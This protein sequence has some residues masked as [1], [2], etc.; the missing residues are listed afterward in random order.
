MSRRRS[1][2]ASTCGG[3]APAAAAPL[4][5][6]AFLHPDL[7]L[8]GAERLVVDAA[9]GLCRL[10]HGVEVF[11]SHYEPARSFAETRS[12][13]FPVHVHGDW[14]PR[15]VLGRLHIL[16]ALLRMLWLALRV[17]LRAGAFDV[18]IVDQVSACVP[19]LKLLCPRAKVL[20]YCASWRARAR[21]AARGGQQPRNQPLTPL[22]PLTS[23]RRP[24]PRPA[25]GA[26]RL[27]PA[28]AV[29]RA[30]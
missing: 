15:A 10:G 23:P 18:L 28:G 22:T 1:S 17:A 2:P 11:T 30:L 3:G 25:A 6:V 14:L 12:G 7:G 20:F 9:A 13:A 21:A 8:G 19:L 5:R 24:L 4:L 26:A 27:A 16:C 29:P